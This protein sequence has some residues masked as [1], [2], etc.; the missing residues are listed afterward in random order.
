MTSE[1][2]HEVNSE[3][4][5]R[6]STFT[7]L[8]G[9]LR[10]HIMKYLLAARH[11]RYE[12]TPDLHGYRFCTNLFRINRQLREE[13]REVFKIQNAFILITTPWAEAL[14]YVSG[15]GI[16]IIAKHKQT[17]VFSEDLS[18]QMVFPDLVIP[19]VSDSP[20]IICV[21]DLA[22]FSLASFYQDISNPGLNANMELTLRMGTQ[23]SNA[24]GPISRSMQYRLLDPFISMK[25]LRALRITGSVDPDVESH[26]REKNSEPHDSAEKCLEASEKLK[27]EGNIMI[28][29]KQFDR[30]KSL[31]EESF[32]AMH[33]VIK[34]RQRQIWGDPYFNRMLAGGQFDGHHGNLVRMELRIKLVANMIEAFLGLELPE[35]AV[36]WGMRSINLVRGNI[37]ED[38]DRPQLGFPAASAWGKVYYRTG[39]AQQ[40]LGNDDEARQLF[41]IAADWLPHDR[42]VQKA[43]ADTALRLG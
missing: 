4:A 23:G 20:F 40:M 37:G 11:V 12:K 33:I 27:G 30:A 1:I 15:I 22:A 41:R 18:A 6:M 2:S 8:P 19:G 10:A 34:G 3:R 9:E 43:R 16:P 21:E 13:A 25:G 17:E 38:A 5:T 42:A 7:S 14:D 29:K 26:F 35:E 24:K 32:R 39:R 36:F 28:N 31:Y